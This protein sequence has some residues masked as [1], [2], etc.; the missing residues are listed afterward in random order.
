MHPPYPT[1]HLSSLVENIHQYISGCVHKIYQ[2]SSFFSSKF[3]TPEAKKPQNIVVSA[4]NSTGFVPHSSKVLETWD[5]TSMAY[6]LSENKFPPGSTQ[7]GCVV[8]VEKRDCLKVTN[9][10][11]SGRSVFDS[12]DFA[13]PDCPPR[14]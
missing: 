9:S 10:H 8:N 1:H 12:A 6:I 7:T 11:T 4:H 14:N 2:V 3:E 13:Q 5:P